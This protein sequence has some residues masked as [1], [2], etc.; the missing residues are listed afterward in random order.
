[1]D[2]LIVNKILR[3]MFDELRSPGPKWP[4]GLVL[5]MDIIFEKVLAAIRVACDSQSYGMTDE[6]ENKFGK[7][8]LQ[9]MT[10]CFR[11]LCACE[12]KRPEEVYEAKK[13]QLRSA[14]NAKD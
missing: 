7:A 13:A 14:L 8:V 6:L 4:E 1:M 3:K 5:Q 12:E 2:Q 9:I 11:W 10:T